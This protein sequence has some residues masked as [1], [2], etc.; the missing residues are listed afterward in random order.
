MLVLK[1]IPVRVSIRLLPT[2]E[3]V[4]PVPNWEEEQLLPTVDKKEMFAKVI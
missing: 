1:T 3:M 4:H 2:V